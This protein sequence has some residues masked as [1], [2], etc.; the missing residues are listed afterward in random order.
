MS[1][2]DWDDL[3]NQEDND[4]AMDLMMNQE[5]NDFAMELMMNQE[6]DDF[7]MDLLFSDTSSLDDILRDSYRGLRPLGNLDPTNPLHRKL[8]D[9]EVRLNIARQN[10]INTH[11]SLQSSKMAL[12]ATQIRHRMVFGPHPSNTPLYSEPLAP[13]TS[14]GTM[15]SGSK[16]R[17]GGS[18]K[19]EMEK[20]PKQME[21]A[22]TG[23]STSP[24][25]LAKDEKSGS[26]TELPEDQFRQKVSEK[27][28]ALRK[29]NEIVGREALG[30]FRM[31]N[32]IHVLH[33]LY[34]DRRVN[35]DLVEINNEIN[36]RWKALTPNQKDHYIQIAVHQYEKKMTY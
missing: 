18:S 11:I 32:R 7:A 33:Q 19:H 31:D 25:N 34:P 17:N 5:D 36:R 3:L 35:P 4:F 8:M 21:V 6:D 14:T 24:K 27:K 15:P 2:N 26:S 20:E 9:S 28:E 12:R 10:L 23:K 22:A 29:R 16:P 13:S 30:W 1:D